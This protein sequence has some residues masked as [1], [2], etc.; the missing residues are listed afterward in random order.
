MDEGRPTRPARA[1]AAADLP[2]R[3]LQPTARYTRVVNGVAAA[4]IPA[5]SRSSSTRPRSRGSTR[6]APPTR[7][8]PGT[9]LE[10]AAFAAG[11]GHR[12]DIG[13]HGIDGRGIEIALLDT[14]VDPTH[15]FLRGQVAPTGSTS[16]AARR[17]RFRPRT[18]TTRPSSSGTGP[19]WPGSS[20]APAARRALRCRDR[21][22]HPPDPRRRLAADR[23]RRPLGLRDDRPGDPGPRGRRRPER[24]RR[25]ARRGPRRAPRA[26]RAV[27]VLPGRSG[28]ARRRR[29]PRGS[30]RSSSRPPG[31]TAPPG[32]SYGSIAGPGRR[33]GRR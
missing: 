21:G 25:R 28:R 27:R 20:S 8:P 1:D 12:P 29:V 6:C 30:T 5:R 14:G 2:R 26:G 13:L 11:S 4:S 3:G 22:E 19:R 18:R 24:G 32:A 23:R 7:R 16:S 33:E 15:P 31:T 17:T 9:L 10:S